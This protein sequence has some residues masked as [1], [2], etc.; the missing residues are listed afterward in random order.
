MQG[1]K[2]YPPEVAYA[3]EIAV[4]QIIIRNDRQLRWREFKQLPEPK[5]E[6]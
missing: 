3:A 1:Q 5:D 2:E 4:W 6:E